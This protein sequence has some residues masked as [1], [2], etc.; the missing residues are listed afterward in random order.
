MN[1]LNGDK[2][3]R[4][5]NHRPHDSRLH[6]HRRVRASARIDLWRGLRGTRLLKSTADL[7]GVGHARHLHQ[8][9]PGWANLLRDE[10]FE[11]TL[12]WSVMSTR[13]IVSDRPIDAH[14]VPIKKCGAKRIAI[15]A[16]RR[17]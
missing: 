14:H 4:T 9:A 5:F 10:I 17:F 7:L 15:S 13:G 8:F 2:S 3:V 12:L 1:K 6:R 16:R 11:G